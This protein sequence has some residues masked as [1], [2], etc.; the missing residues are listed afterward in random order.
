MEWAN[1][2]YKIV[3]MQNK[4]VMPHRV[5]D[6]AISKQQEQVDRLVYVERRL[7]RAERKGRS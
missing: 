1:R 6:L 4:Y 3:F 2:S 5:S 7:Q